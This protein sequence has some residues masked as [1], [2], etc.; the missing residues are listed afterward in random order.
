MVS[1]ILSWHDSCEFRLCSQSWLSKNSQL[2]QIYNYMTWQ[3]WKIKTWT[4][5][6]RRIKCSVHITMK[7]QTIRTKG[8]CSVVWI[9]SVS[10]PF[11]YTESSLHVGLTLHHPNDVRTVPLQRYRVPQRRCAFQHFPNVNTELYSQADRDVAGI[12]RLWCSCLL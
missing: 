3:S 8:L 10:H 7:P 9:E 5:Q 1:T 4:M 11:R 2:L 12:T 6:E